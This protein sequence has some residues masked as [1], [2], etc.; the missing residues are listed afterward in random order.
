[1][2]YPDPPPNPE[3]EIMKSLTEFTIHVKDR[4]L[5]QDFLSTWDTQCGEPFKEAIMKGKP[6]FNVRD[7]A[8]PVTTPKLLLPQ[9]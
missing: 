7:N 3:L 1:M 6:K 9:T 2:E 8:R 5:H 4:V